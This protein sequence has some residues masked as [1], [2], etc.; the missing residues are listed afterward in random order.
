LTD[1]VRVF[2]GAVIKAL[3]VCDLI[4]ALKVT[5][6]RLAH[7][8]AHQELELVNVQDDALRP[9]LQLRVVHQVMHQ[10]FMG[11]N[12][13]QAAVIEM[14]V[15]VSRLSMLPQDKVIAEQQYLQIA[16]DKTAGEHELEAWGWLIAKVNQFYAQQD[17]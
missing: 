16:I 11:F 9:E 2:A 4:P 17:K 1:D 10:P 8:L 5:G 6:F 12:R 7:T 15:L 13:A 3:P 14:A